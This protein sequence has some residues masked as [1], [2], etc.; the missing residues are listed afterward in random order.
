MEARENV[1]KAIC[2]II[3]NR[4]GGNASAFARRIGMSRQV[5]SN[6]V[7]GHRSP[8]I[9]TVADICRLY[10]VSINWM[11]LGEDDD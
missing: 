8:D 9:E 2:W 6:W 4:E 10:D 5:V 11:I 3:E 7:N 1:R